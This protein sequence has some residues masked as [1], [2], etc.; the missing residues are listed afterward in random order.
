MSLFVGES[1]FLN[2]ATGACTLILTGHTNSVR[3]VGWSPDGQHIAT[4]SGD[5]TARIWDAATGACTLTLTGH[6]GS[7]RG[8]GWAADGK[9]VA[10]ASDGG[11]DRNREPP[12]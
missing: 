5:R 6:T 10:P 2:A 4:T 11:T 3:G 8:V 7:V 12:Q 1:P 9:H